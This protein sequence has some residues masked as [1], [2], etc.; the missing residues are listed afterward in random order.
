MTQS[1]ETLLAD[2]ESR[3]IELKRDG[4]A[5]IARPRQKLGDT[6][7]AAIRGNQ[8][9]LLKALARITASHDQPSAHLP[10]AA[11][12]DLEAIA[13]AIDAEPR[14]PVL[15]DLALAHAARV[16][17]TAIQIIRT[18]PKATRRGASRLA[19]T[20]SRRVVR[21]IRKRDYERAY[22]ALDAL[23]DELKGLIPQ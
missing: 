19:V 12:I 7:R 5:L 13:D 1:I 14:S 21:A 15:N 18:L 8:A 11:W 16:A 10:L 23:P 6:D 4:N 9:A 22:Q 17:V 20:V 3:G 2:F